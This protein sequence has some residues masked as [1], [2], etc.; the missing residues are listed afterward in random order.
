MKNY[1]IRVKKEFFIKNPQGADQ[2]VENLTS[3]GVYVVLGTIGDR[4]LIRG[5]N[6]SIVS[7]Y[8]RWCIFERFLSG[9]DRISMKLVPEDVSI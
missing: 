8:P 6:D 7:L 9:E 5:E 2:E 3:N 1:L 4:L